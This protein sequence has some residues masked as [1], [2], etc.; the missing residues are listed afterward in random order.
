MN[1]FMRFFDSFASPL[2]S[3]DAEGRQVYFPS[4]AW[5]AGYLPKDAAAAD[6]LRTKVRYSFIVF[7]VVVLPVVI[8]FIP[9]DNPGDV[10]FL[11]GVS[12]GIGLIF[13]IVLRF[14]AL[15]LQR[16]DARITF[17]EA[18]QRHLKTLG[19]GWLI[20]MIILSLPLIGLGAAILAIGEPEAAWLGW[21]LIAMF[22]ACLVTFIVSLRA[23]TRAKA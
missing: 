22:G 5:G 12:I 9:L 7:F 21:T 13:N 8:Q 11:M 14:Y 17:G 23:H 15:G 10:P 18:R 19:R 6:K 1:A 3:E 4:G 20:A 16:S 2:F